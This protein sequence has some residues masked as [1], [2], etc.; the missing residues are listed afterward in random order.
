M[1][2]WNKTEYRAKE[3][4]CQ[5]TTEAAISISSEKRLYLCTKNGERS[6]SRLQGRIKSDIKEFDEARQSTS[7]TLVRSRFMANVKGFGSKHSVSLT[8]V[9]NATEYN[10]NLE[11]PRRC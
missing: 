6:I 5:L 10:Y 8:K 9:R 4:R 1:P 3:L 11:T 2:G 7:E